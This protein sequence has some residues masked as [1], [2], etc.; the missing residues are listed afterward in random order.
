MES[1][2]YTDRKFIEA[3]RA[4]VNVAAHED[5]GHE[6]DAQVQGRK[7]TVCEHYWNIPCK[8][9]QASYHQTRKQFEKIKDMP[10]TVLAAP[11]GKELGRELGLKS[12]SELMKSMEK[13]FNQVPGEKVG[14]V[15]WRQ[16]LKLVADGDAAFEKGEWKKSVEALLKVTKLPKKALKDLGAPGI[17]KLET[18]GRELI[19][20]AN[21]KLG[22]PEEK[23]KLLKKVVEDF[24]PL[25]CA[26]EAA[27][28]LQ[29]MPPPKKE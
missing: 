28:A 23:R 1:S 11:N 5:V 19:E 12:S 29:A 3:S 25:S 9:H 6:V 24:K 7:V 15:E 21:Q 13:V 4:W 17:Q 14:A 22:E 8:S 20:D 27:A 18:K 26:K 10:V 2:T 16:A